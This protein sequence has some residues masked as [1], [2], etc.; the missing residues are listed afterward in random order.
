MRWPI[1]KFY[2]GRGFII[3]QNTLLLSYGFLINLAYGSKME[4]QETP[5]YP[6]ERIA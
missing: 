5:F 2:I 3:S 6:K 4:S 1:M